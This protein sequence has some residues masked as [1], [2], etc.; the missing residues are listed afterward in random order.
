MNRSK[1]H[2]EPFINI[3]FG[4]I[5]LTSKVIAVLK[6]D[7][8]PIKRILQEAKDKDLYLDATY[9][10]KTRSILVTTTHHVIASP[11]AVDTLTTRLCNMTTQDKEEDL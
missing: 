3:G 4:N 8:S 6:P 5:V 2:V 10:R 7:S 1:S 11:L 9:G